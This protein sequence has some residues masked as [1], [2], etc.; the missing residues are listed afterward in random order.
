MT[1]R[2]KI[3]KLLGEN[4][5]TFSENIAE[6]LFRTVAAFITGTLA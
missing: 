2:A 3:L 1:D 6:F 5:A 4:K